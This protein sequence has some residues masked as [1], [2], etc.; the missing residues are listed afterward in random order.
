MIAFKRYGID[1]V[2]PSFATMKGNAVVLARSVNGMSSKAGPATIS[3]S[4]SWTCP[5]PKDAAAAAR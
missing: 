5:P 4:H 2:E 3:H 1:A